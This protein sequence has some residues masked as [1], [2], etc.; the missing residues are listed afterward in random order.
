MHFGALQFQVLI[1]VWIPVLLTSGALDMSSFGITR[2]MLTTFSLCFRSLVHQHCQR[3]R[4]QL[5]QSHH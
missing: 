5:N 3:Q 1:L 2:M 4:Y